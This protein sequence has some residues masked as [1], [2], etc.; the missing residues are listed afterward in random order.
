M[1]QNANAVISEAIE[2]IEERAYKNSD[3]NVILRVDYMMNYVSSKLISILF[4]ADVAGDSKKEDFAQ[5]CNI[6]IAKNGGKAYLADLGFTKED[7]VEEC[8]IVGE[9]SGKYRCTSGRL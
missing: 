6:N 1:T 4:I 3:E 7:I 2:K 9:K 5:R 8:S